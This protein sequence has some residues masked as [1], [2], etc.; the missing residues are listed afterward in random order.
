MVSGTREGRPP[1]NHKKNRHHLPRSFPSGP[2]LSGF[3]PAFVRHLSGICLA[4]VQHLSGSCPAGQNLKTPAVFQGFHLPDNCRTSAGQRPLSGICPAF[5]RLFVRL[6]SGNCPGHPWRPSWRPLGSSWGSLATL[7]G[8]LGAHLGIPGDPPGTLGDLPGVPGDPPGVPR[9]PRGPPRDPQ[10]V[11]RGFRRSLGDPKSLKILEKSMKTRENPRKS[12]NIDPLITCRPGGPG[13][14]GP[15][16][17]LAP[18]PPGPL[19]PSPLASSG[20]GPAAEA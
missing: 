13:P 16:G 15:P 20:K 6:L 2:P 19:A 8:I 18:W 9:L 14:P 1:K 7:L 4:F 12:V 10:G 11:P 3:C 5:V 17:S